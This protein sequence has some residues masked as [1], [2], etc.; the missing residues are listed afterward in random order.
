MGPDL[1][2]DAIFSGRDINI[3]REFLIKDFLT[4]SIESVHCR[5]RIMLLNKS[6]DPIP[7]IGDLMPISIIGTMQK[8]LETSIVHHLKEK[9]EIP[10]HSSSDSNLV[11]AWERRSLD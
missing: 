2:P 7:D 4:T 8:I 11:Q 10:L 6:K 3:K 9:M 1:I 5:S